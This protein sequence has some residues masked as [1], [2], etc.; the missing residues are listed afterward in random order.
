MKPSGFFRKISSCAG[1]V[2]TIAGAFA[3]ISGI[4]ENLIAKL[5]K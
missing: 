3:I 5:E 4:F 2:A 1:S